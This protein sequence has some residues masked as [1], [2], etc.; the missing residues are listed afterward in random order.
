[1]FDEVAIIEMVW[2]LNN[3]QDSNASFRYPDDSAEIGR[4]LNLTTWLTEVF[5]RCPKYDQVFLPL[6]Q[7]TAETKKVKVAFGVKIVTGIH[8]D[9]S[10]VEINHL[11]HILPQK[12]DHWGSSIEQISQSGSRQCQKEARVAF[13][14][15]LQI[16]SIFVPKCLKTGVGWME[17]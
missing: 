11:K 9:D 3:H 1:M 7:K 6:S 13:T 10:M 14:K 17:Y 8:T 16:P 4:V 5:E 2:E 12:L 15:S